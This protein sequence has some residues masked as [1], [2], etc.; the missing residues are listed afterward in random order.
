MIDDSPYTQQQ[1]NAFQKLL[2]DAR[3][4]R[5]L[6]QTQVANQIGVSQ[7]LISNLERGPTSGMRVAEL[8]KV[9][10]YYRIEPNL[11]AETLGYWDEGSIANP[12]N[13]PRF[14]SVIAG[15]ANLPDD[16]CDQVLTAIELMLRGA[17]NGQ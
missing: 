17:A 15:L 9:L 16:L 7:T 3:R 11:I 1:V 6:N 13:D 8:F 12:N 5:G 14:T 2:L 4:I 10:S